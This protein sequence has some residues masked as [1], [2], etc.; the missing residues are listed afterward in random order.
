MIVKSSAA[1]CFV[2][3]C[4]PCIAP[5]ILRAQP[6]L[7]LLA[8]CWSLGVVLLEMIGGKGSFAKAV[9]LS[10]AEL[11][12]KPEEG[13]KQAVAIAVKIEDFFQAKNSHHLALSCKNNSTS[14]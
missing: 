9:Q 10:E 3:G 11:Q 14:Q 6:Y 7:P 8:D 4:L 2:C 1:S 5:E 13:A 12:C